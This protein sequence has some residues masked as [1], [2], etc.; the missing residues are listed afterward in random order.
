MTVTETSHVFLRRQEDVGGG[1][2]HARTSM[3]GRPEISRFARPSMLARNG[4][5]SEPFGEAW[6]CWRAP[7][8]QS[9]ATS[10]QSAPCAYHDLKVP[11]TFARFIH[12]ALADQTKECPRPS[13]PHVVVQ[14]A[15]ELEIESS[16]RWYPSNLRDFPPLL[17]LINI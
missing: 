7:Q 9:R 6:Q 4:E 5:M 12:R 10:L 16:S 3:P 11:R 1:A 8:A 2:S 15:R 14:D 13:V 17:N